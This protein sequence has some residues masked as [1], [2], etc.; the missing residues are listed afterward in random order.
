MTIFDHYHLKII[1]ST[2]SFPEFVLAWKND[3]I[4]SAH[5]W[6]LWPDWTHLF[7]NMH[8]QKNFDF[9]DH[10]STCKKS[11]YL[12]HLLILQI[13]SILESHHQ[14]G[15]THFWPRS[16]FTMST[17]IFVWNCTSMQKNQIHQFFLE[18]ESILES[19]DQIGHIPFWPCPNK[20]FSINF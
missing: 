7:L 4:S 17:P 14:N 13:Q 5:F 12:F 20:N 19:R 8:T 10:A 16:F 1:E 11:D 6:A 3:F 9:C 18:I 15:H 2:F